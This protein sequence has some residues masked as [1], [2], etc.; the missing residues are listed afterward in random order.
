MWVPSG[1]RVPSCLSFKWITVG[2][3]SPCLHPVQCPVVLQHLSGKQRLFR[4]QS[5]L[6]AQ[7]REW[8]SGSVEEAQTVRFRIN[9]VQV[10]SSFT[11]WCGNSV[12]SLSFKVQSCHCCHLSRAV[13]PLPPP[14]DPSCSL[15]F[16]DWV[17]GEGGWNHRYYCEHLTSWR[18]SSGPRC[19]N[20]MTWNLFSC[21]W[22][23]SCDLPLLSEDQ[24]KPEATSFPSEGIS[25][26]YFFANKSDCR[27]LSI[28]SNNIFAAFK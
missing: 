27:V 10:P 4:K 28:K 5:S 22:L 8:F 13:Q 17:C 3:H 24:E 14:D 2:I 11:S 23:P 21:L 6:G 25:N 9:T 1:G 19:D 20:C 18:A 12:N 26:L 7:W 16:E 15:D